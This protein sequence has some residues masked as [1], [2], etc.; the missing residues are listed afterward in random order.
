MKILYI[1][2]HAKS[3][4]EDSTMSDF[5]RPLNNRGLHDAP[6]MGLKLKELGFIPDQIISSSANRALSTAKLLAESISHPLSKI[7]ET[8]A[9]YLADLSTMLKIVNS[10]NDEI[11]SLM[12]VGHNPGMTQIINYLA[13]ENLF[14]L[15]TCS[16]SG[17]RF[18]IDN[19]EA[20]SMGLGKQFVYEYPKKYK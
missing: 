15:P 2:R 9:L 5:D 3:S 14:N 13:A 11:D 20:V 1:V 16:L 8:K 4:W 17:I 12:L 19:W 6:M 10:V 18:F 7:I